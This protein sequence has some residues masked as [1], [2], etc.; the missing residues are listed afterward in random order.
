[1]FHENKL[2]ELNLDVT[3]TDFTQAMI[4]KEKE[5]TKEIKG[6]KIYEIAD[7]DNLEKYFGE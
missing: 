7:V 1:M 2:N 3:F 5:N 6:N 4:D